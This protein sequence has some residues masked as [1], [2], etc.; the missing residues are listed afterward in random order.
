[1]GELHRSNLHFQCSYLVYSAQKI[2]Y[3]S[4]TLIFKYLS[5]VPVLEKVRDTVCSKLNSGSFAPEIR[6]VFWP[7]SDENCSRVVSSDWNCIKW[8]PQG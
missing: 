4:R 6:G 8:V 2:D 3:S 7:K 5:E 1:M